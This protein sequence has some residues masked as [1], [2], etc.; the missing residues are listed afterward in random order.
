MIDHTG[1]GAEVP[2]AAGSVELLSGKPAD[3]TVTVAPGEVAVVRE[4]RGQ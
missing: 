2:V 4:P 1:E 3:G